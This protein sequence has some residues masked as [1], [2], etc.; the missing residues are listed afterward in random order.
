MFFHCIC[1]ATLE[2]RMRECRCVG[3]DIRDIV[4]LIYLLHIQKAQDEIVVNRLSQISSV[5]LGICY[6]SD[7]K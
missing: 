1:T 5:P 6:N 3:V 2:G 7:L 4:G